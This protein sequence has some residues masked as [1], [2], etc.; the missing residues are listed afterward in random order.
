MGRNN[1]KI[2]CDLCKKPHRTRGTIAYKNL[3]VCK[4]CYLKLT[5]RIP[6]PL[7]DGA[8]SLEK[9]LNKT[10]K[11]IGYITNRGHLVASFST[12][13]ILIGHKIKLVLVD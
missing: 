2:N 1:G 7:R 10:Y 4:P 11:V 13:S 5:A 8:F 9:A 3:F 12:P 6:T